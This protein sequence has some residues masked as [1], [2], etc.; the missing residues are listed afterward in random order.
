MGRK[1]MLGSLQE[2]NDGFFQE[3]ECIKE[4]CSVSVRYRKGGNYY[5]GEYKK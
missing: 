2:S 5:F 3:D 1:E 4:Y